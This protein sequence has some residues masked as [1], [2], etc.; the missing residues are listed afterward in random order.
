VPSNAVAYFT[1]PFSAASTPTAT[2]ATGSGGE[3]AGLAVDGSGNVIASD[4]NLHT[5]TGYTR[6]SP[7]AATLFA[8]SASF[9]PGGIA[10]DTLGKLYVADYDAGGGVDVVSP[11]FSNSSVPQALI[12]GLTG[13]DALCFDGS[14]N[15]YTVTYGSGSTIRVYA[16]PYTG[17]PITLATGYNNVD[18]CAFNT[19]TNQLAVNVVGV[20]SGNVLVYSLPLT[21]ASVPAAV[22]P[23]SSSS[24]TAVAFDASGRL[25]V[26][27][28]ASTIDVY[29]P[30]IT[31][32]S[33]PLFGI[34]TVNAVEAMAFGQ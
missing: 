3:I 32:A 7:T 20:F 13:V 6:P 15:L 18:G 10:F 14:Q 26:G 12:T 27:V 16:P 21:A 9:T 22:L 30:P 28:G 23:Y 33:T 5:I 25:Y 31:S 24:S 2:F 17:A 4:Q 8:I 29:Q 34:P 1:A 11:P 19:V